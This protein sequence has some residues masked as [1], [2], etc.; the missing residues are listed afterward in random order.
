M[1][2]SYSS[3]TLDYEKN[4]NGPVPRGFFTRLSL[5]SGVLN[6]ELSHTGV[7]SDHEK[8]QKLFDQVK[9]ILASH[10]HARPRRGA[11]VEND[12]A[13]IE[14]VNL[15]RLS[16]QEQ[17]GSLLNDDSD[18]EFEE[19]FA[20]GQH[21]VAHHMSHS[22]HTL[23]SDLGVGLE[24]GL[25]TADLMTRLGFKGKSTLPFM[26]QTRSTKPYAVWT[27]GLPTSKIHEM[28][29]RGTEPNYVK[30]SLR[31]HQLAGVAAALRIL[32]LSSGGVLFADDTGIG[33]T[34]QSYGVL[35]IMMHRAEAHNEGFDVGGV[36]L[37]AR[38]PIPVG[39][40]VIIAPTSLIDNWK[41]EG[42]MW[43]DITV[44]FFVYEGSAAA[45][46]DFFAPGSKFDQSNTKMYQRI[47][48]VS[49]SVFKCFLYVIYT[50]N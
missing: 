11:P 17:F 50:N 48:L 12:A 32:S 35:A 22:A 39:P 16:Y 37:L 30:L 28:I 33:K 38:L 15:A 10:P 14:E 42:I 36:R 19:H 45:R 43:L 1:I 47:I 8:A 3:H 29:R 21:L 31:W 2:Y 41:A 34:S 24:C 4:S 26:H 46:K 44:E 27:A 9:S 13:L 18:D 49:T 5:L 25:S 40:H 7:Q 23:S 20:T 6:R